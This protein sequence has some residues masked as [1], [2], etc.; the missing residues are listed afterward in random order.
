M[1]LEIVGKILKIVVKRKVV[2]EEF[3]IISIEVLDVLVVK[4]DFEKV[5][6]FLLILEIGFVQLFDLVN[7]KQ[8]LVGVG[9]FVDIEVFLY[10]VVF[11][12][13]IGIF[14]QF[15]YIELF[16]LLYIGEV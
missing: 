9:D 16:V 1:G 8:V 3:I 7:M 5:V 4:L 14:S 15:V 13:F 6:G 11:E 12:Y 10:D 2:N